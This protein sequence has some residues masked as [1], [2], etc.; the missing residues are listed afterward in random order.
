MEELQVKVDDYGD[1]GAVGGV[2]VDSIVDNGDNQAIGHT[3]VD[4]KA[5]QRWKM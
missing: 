1:D 3:Y 4:A 5:K 2:T